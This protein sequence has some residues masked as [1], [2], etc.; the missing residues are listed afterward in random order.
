[1]NSTH[2]LRDEYLVQDLKDLTTHVINPNTAYHLFD[3]ST[4][5]CLERRCESSNNYIL[6]AR[7]LDK[8]IFKIFCS[9]LEGNVCG[10]YGIDV[11]HHDNVQSLCN[12][13]Q[14]ITRNLAHNTTLS[15]KLWH[16]NDAFV[17]Y[18]CYFWCT[19]DGNI[20]TKKEEDFN[21]AMQ[22]HLDDLHDT[23]V[24]VKASNLLETPLAYGR[25][26]HLTLN[27]REDSTS[28]SYHW[29]QDATCFATV[30]CDVLTGNACGTYGLTVSNSSQSV[31]I[32][33][34]LVM[35]KI[36]IANVLNISL[37]KE[38]SAK[39]NLSCYLWCSKQTSRN[40]PAKPPARSA[41]FDLV[42]KISALVT[43]FC[44]LKLTWNDF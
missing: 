1:M 10:S 35:Y 16:S 36:E 43:I 38:N 34:T 27:D 9:R 2:S 26:Y 30:T 22:A 21:Q 11:L 28:A 15:L 14:L 33:Q 31:Q 5:E 42:N 8:C 44:T 20:P 25:I 39:F 40:L 23:Q 19:G 12:R 29:Y 6:L 32:C 18:A 7:S 37:W 13:G 24:F 17:D 4:Q 3:N 41:T